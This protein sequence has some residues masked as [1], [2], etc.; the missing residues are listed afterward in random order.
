MDKDKLEKLKS[1]FEKAEILA[2][3]R[4]QKK[5]QELIDGKLEDIQSKILVSFDSNSNSILDLFLA[6]QP[7]LDEISDIRTEMVSTCIHPEEMLIEQDN[8]VIL[9]KFC[10]KQLKII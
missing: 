9:C 6:R 5:M 7:I 2:W 4:K 8:D 10:N 1:N 3:K